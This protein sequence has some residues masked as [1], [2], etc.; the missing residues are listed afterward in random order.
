MPAAKADA[1]S[2]TAGVEADPLPGTKT[3]AS[4]VK[5]TAPGR[6]ELGLEGT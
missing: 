1:S 4:F 2:V 5:E 3:G 6:G